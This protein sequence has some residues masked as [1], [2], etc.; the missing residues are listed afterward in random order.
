MDFSQES[1][2]E[3]TQN[4]ERS[5]RQKSLRGRGGNSENQKEEQTDWL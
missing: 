5:H 3:E 2:Q 1:L 4:Q